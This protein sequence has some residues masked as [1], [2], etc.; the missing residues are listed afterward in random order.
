[1]SIAKMDDV[2]FKNMLF[3]LL[4][5]FPYQSTSLPL[6]TN[7]RAPMASKNPL[8]FCP[9][10][11]TVCCT[12]SEDS[13]IEKN[14]QNMN[15]SDPT[16]SSIV[17][18]V[19]CATCDKFSAELYKISSPSPRSVPVLCESS[20]SAVK[21]SSLATPGNR[22]F[23]SSVWDACQNS[24]IANSPFAPS[25]Q[26]TAGVS[27]NSSASKLTDLWQSKDDFCRAFG[28]PLAD[29]S[30]CYSGKPIE[31]NKTETIPPSGMC[32][33][34]IGDGTYLNMV[35]H[36]DGS[37]RAFFATQ[38]GK[39]FLATIPD[40]DSGQALG[41]DESSP[42]V[43][44][45][46]Q[47]HLDTNFGLFGLAFHPNFSQN[48]RFFA[49]FNCDKV[50]N[51]GCFGRCACNSD[52]GCD[53]SKLGAPASSQP[54]Q[55]HTIVSEYTANGTEAA[56]SMAQ[57]AKPTEVRRIF[58]MGL[59]YKSTAG[60]QLLFGPQ[61]GYLY[62]MMG[63]GGPKGDPLNF[64]QNK[65]SLLG[66]IMRLDVDN[67]PSKQETAD[68]HSWGNYSTP[69]D[70]PY[71]DDKELAPEIWALGLRNPWRCSFDSERPSYFICGDVGQ[72]TY[73]EVD[74]ITKG[75]NY[76]WRVYEG[77]LVFTS[78]PASGSNTSADS[79]EPIL[80]VA[81]YTHSEVNKKTGSASIS[82]GYVYR[83]KTDPCMYG[84]YLYGDLYG[85]NIWAALE[86]PI[87]SGKF[88]AQNIT[89]GCAQDT[90]MSCA[91]AAKG[92]LPALGYV[93]SSGQDNNKDVFILTSSG[94]YRIVRPSRCNYSCSKE[95][96]TTNAKPTPPA[97]SHTQHI[98]PHLVP[99]L[100]L[101]LLLLL[102]EV[103]Y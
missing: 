48:G 10:N 85:E 84:S 70:N 79:I 55:F 74:I 46:D 13:Q 17:K 89:F 31:L 81:G 56:P 38:A 57:H 9:Y 97:P 14:F 63:D 93:F 72:D 64:S 51:P 87:D 32:L 69:R 96:P 62:L 7:L 11:G 30:L 99:A 83:S 5:L 65:K 67:I 52:V 102:L 18:S 6:C 36:P 33:E 54:C 8:D 16:C 60:G 91:S 29:D 47:V 43:D 103:P 19:I 35:A 26:N 1:M 34:K 58:S 49:S 2:F 27:Q 23:C 100:F 20:A 59:P 37:N 95:T 101:S 80:P 68:L 77:P 40:Q 22:K 82:G 42:F 78:Q 12:S 4:L 98:R 24:L 71:A 39:V 86:N 66:K 73:E 3:C 88:S 45:S 50:T 61:D 25:L 92:P 21:L 76:G 94:V 90:P 28:A 75:G 44:L 53:P 15:I 41:L